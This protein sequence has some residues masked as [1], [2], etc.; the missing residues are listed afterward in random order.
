MAMCIPLEQAW[1]TT[2]PPKI[3]MSVEAVYRFTTTDY[4]DDVSTTYAGTGINGDTMHSPMAPVGYP[5]P[6][7]CCKTA[8]M[9]LT[10]FVLGHEGRQRGWSK[11][12]DQYVM[13]EV[14]FSF[15]I[16][17]YR[18]PSSNWSYITY[19]ITASS[20]G[21]FYLPGPRFGLIPPVLNIKPPKRYSVKF[22]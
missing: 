19:K 14:G 18:C 17:T 20:F 11:Q 9:K 3:N 4:L 7:N 13:L 15:N 10:C 22:C 12:K 6:P 1:N 21:A 16:S 2:S 8:L 5:L